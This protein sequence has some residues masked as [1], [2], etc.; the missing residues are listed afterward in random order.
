MKSKA[1]LG[2]FRWKKITEA[3]KTIIYLSSDCKMLVSAAFKEPTIK[4][5]PCCQIIRC[6][7]H[8]KSLILKMVCRM[9]ELHLWV[10]HFEKRSSAKT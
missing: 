1:N 7:T 8:K 4:Q 3:N 6:A 9:L 5:C 2:K 10:L